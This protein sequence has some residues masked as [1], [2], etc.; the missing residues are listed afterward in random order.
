MRIGNKF[1]PLKRDNYDTPIEAWDLLLSK[2][3]T[4]PE[5]I[6]SPFYNTGSLKNKLKTRNVSII[7]EN[8]DFFKY[9][10]TEWDIC[11]DNPPYSNKK[12][13]FERLKKL[14]KPFALLVPIDT[15]ERVYFKT[16]FGHSNKLQVIIPSKRYNF[17]GY[18]NKKNVPFKTI[19]ICYGLDLNSENQLIFE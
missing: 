15:L 2:M 3:K 14:D 1:T 12:A 7:H 18:D 9:E 16:I 13:I 8:L 4:I 10:P 19:W 6:W 17:T 5:N 11:V